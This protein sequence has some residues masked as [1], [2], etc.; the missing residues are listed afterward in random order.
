MQIYFWTP[1]SS[2]LS[3]YTFCT[4]MFQYIQFDRR[5]LTSPRGPLSPY[6]EARPTAFHTYPFLGISFADR[7]VGGFMKFPIYSRCFLCPPPSD[8]F[9]SICNK[10]TTSPKTYIK[11]LSR[12]WNIYYRF[13]YI[14]PSFPSSVLNQI[15]VSFSPLLSLLGYLVVFSEMS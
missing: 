2:P 7:Q 1:T 9:P 12:I 11:Y 4:E 13:E 8:L 6:F 15:L 3:C 5:G 14:D 10:N